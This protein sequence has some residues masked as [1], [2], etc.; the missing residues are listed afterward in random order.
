[1]KT[2]WKAAFVLMVLGLAA[3]AGIFIYFERQQE[4]SKLTDEVRTNAPGSFVRL[5]NGLVHYNLDGPEVAET[6]VFIHGGGITGAEV[7]DK[8]LSFF[9]DKGYKTLSYDLYGRGYSDRPSSKHSPELF[10]RQL[11]QL[12]D[13]LQI[14][15]KVNLVALSM[16]AIVALDFA[17]LFPHRVRKVVLIDPA[18]SGNYKP[19]A[20]LTIPVLSEFLLTTYWYPRAVENQRKE[21]V[22]QELFNTYSSRL[23]YFM[24]FEGYKHTNY[25]TWMNM[26]NQDKVELVSKLPSGNLMLIYGD[27]DPYFNEKQNERY[28]SHG[29]AMK[30][31]KVKASG[32]MPNM[33][34][35]G[36]VNQAIYDFLQQ[37]GEEERFSSGV[38]THQP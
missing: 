24:D 35:P 22:N 34:Q 31:V 1:M 15:G 4:T 2:F 11:V 33:E 3:L 13:T 25:S 18:A 16:G 37:E 5:E 8:N 6:I 29:P 20:L 14:N 17:H 28:Q 7:W 38:G 23:R 32:H 12:L 30:I 9:L 26:L 36:L 27:A 19:N 10:H 21:F